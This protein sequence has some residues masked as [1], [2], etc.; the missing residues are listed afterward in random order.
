M[1]RGV[2]I[3]WGVGIP[4]QEVVGVGLERMTLEAVALMEGLLPGSTSE[5]VILAAVTLVGVTL[6]GLMLETLTLV[7]IM[8]SE[9]IPSEE[10]AL[11]W[12]ML[13]MLLITSES[14][15]ST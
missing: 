11:K 13:W 4:A 14:I 10:V 3:I 12:L 1:L 15:T 2:G 8:L 9:W 7:Q 6:E 5:V